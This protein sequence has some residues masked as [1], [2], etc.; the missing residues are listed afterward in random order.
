[1]EC[2]IK[3]IGLFSIVDSVFAERTLLIIRVLTKAFDGK[4]FIFREIFTVFHEHSERREREPISND[5]SYLIHAINGLE[6]SV[7]LIFLDL[8]E[9]SHIV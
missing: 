4:G 5:S 2:S 6:L 1:M 9:P 8:C 3:S 7:V